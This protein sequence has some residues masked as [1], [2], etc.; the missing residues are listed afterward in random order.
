[1]TG[2]LTGESIAQNGQA[3]RK[4]T[5][6]PKCDERWADRWINSPVAR[7][8]RFG[9]RYD[10]SRSTATASLGQK[11]TLASGSLRAAHWRRKVS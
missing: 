1:M 10:C 6:R 11:R 4:S 9:D 5:G 8:Y 2:A 7:G 3:T